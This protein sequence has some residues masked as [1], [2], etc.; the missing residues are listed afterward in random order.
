MK[1]RSRYGMVKTDTLDSLDRYVDHRIPTGGFLY[2]VLTNN[3]FEAFGRADRE[4]S[5]TLREICDYIYSELPA[6]CWGSMEKVAWWL[7]GGKQ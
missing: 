3:L 4:N 1:D 5:D 6:G 2:A 7:K